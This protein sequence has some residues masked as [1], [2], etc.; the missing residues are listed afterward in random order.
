LF[1]RIYV[2]TND[3]DSALAVTFG[4]TEKGI[5]FNGDFNGNVGP[6]VRL[7][8]LAG[9]TVDLAAHNGV[10]AAYDYAADAF[11]LANAYRVWIDV[12]NKAFDVQGGVQMGGDV[13]SVFVQR[14]GAATRTTLF[15]N[16]VSDRDAANVDPF[17]GAPTTN[18]T[19]LFFSALGANQGTNNVFFDDFYLSSNGINATTPVPASSF[20]PGTPPAAEIRVTGFSYT[21]TSFALTWS[22]TAGQTYTVQKRAAVDTGTWTT[23]VTG[24]PAG[25]AT[26]TSATYTDTGASANASFYRISSP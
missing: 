24:H 11:Q 26:G 3:L 10:G 14:E 17:F 21:G 4:L 2:P 22:A 20:V 9:G 8:R 18:L 1:F 6:Y 12:D 13:Y 5:R 19:H 16:Y 7:E 23:V 15:E 25:G